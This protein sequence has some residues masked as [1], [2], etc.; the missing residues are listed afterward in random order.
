MS[1]ITDIKKITKAIGIPIKDWAG[2]CFAIACACV[3]KKMVSGKP[4]YGH[5]R[6]Y[7]HKDSIFSGHINMGWCQHG[8]VELPDGRIF[9][10]TRWAFECAEPY[11]YVGDNKGQYDVGGNITRAKYRTPPPKFDSTKKT[12]DIKPPE[13]LTLLIRAMLD[14]DSEVVVKDILD[15]KRTIYTFTVEQLAW[16]ACANPNDLGDLA[17]EFYGVLKSKEL[18]AFIPIDNWRLIME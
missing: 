2:S 14:E 12:L 1:T 16:L 3:D 7:I 10:P 11:I 4:R 8:W 15:R 13:K 6:G 5:Y 18:D 9:D 17:K